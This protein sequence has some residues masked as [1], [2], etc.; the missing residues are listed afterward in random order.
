MVHS[1]KIKNIVE[2]TV[3]SNRQISYQK[4]THQSS[5]ITKVLLEDCQVFCGGKASVFELEPTSIGEH[6]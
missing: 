1:A 4:S 5:G 3:T 2:N 6:I